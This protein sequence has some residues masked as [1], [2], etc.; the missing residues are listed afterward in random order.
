MA[1]YCIHCKSSNVEERVEENRIVYVCPDCS[2]KSGKAL[3]VDGKIKI[4]STSRGIK[5]IDVAA[6]VIQDDKILLMER[7]TFPY[8]LTL[9]AGH[10]EYSESLEE[11]LEREVYEETGIKVKGATLVGQFEQPE[12][13]CRYGADVEEWA[14]FLV[15]HGAK[16]DVI[17]RNNETEDAYWFPLNALPYDKL[18]PHTKFA[19]VLLGYV[20][21]VAKS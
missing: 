1:T 13:Y 4:I 14:V 16:D 3:V 18:S 6:L 15:D 8:G 2:E 9:P 10:L 7:R 19:L 20:K 11:A 12:S 17:V 21:E 5:H